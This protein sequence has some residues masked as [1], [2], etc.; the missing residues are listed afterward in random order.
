MK[1]TNFLKNTICQNSHKKKLTILLW[2]YLF[3]KLK[4]VMNS[5]PK[6]KALNPDGKTGGSYQTLKKE[7]M[8]VLYHFFQRREAEGI[9]PRSFYEASVL[10]IPKPDADITYEWGANFRA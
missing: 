8:P 7:I 2:L 3:K 1:L 9:I 6:Q 10:L 5:L 4:A